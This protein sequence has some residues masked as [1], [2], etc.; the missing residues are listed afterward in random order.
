M[1]CCVGP[2]R[3]TCGHVGRRPPGNAGRGKVTDDTA[4]HVENDPAGKQPASGRFAAHCRDA[5]VTS[6]RATREAWPGRTAHE[7]FE[8]VAALVVTGLVSVLIA[9]A[10]VHLTWE[11][12]VLV[13]MGLADPAGK[14][15]FQ[16][17][18]G[19]IMTVL[20]ALEFNHSIRGVSERRHGII[21]VRTV[22][23][24]ALLARVR[25]FVTI[26]ATHVAPVRAD[27]LLR[28]G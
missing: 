6:L 20:M 19:M 21:Q 10:P 11:V 23:L 24:I 26:D 8:Q 12:L 13:L 16:A 5:A 7:R 22:V 9:A 28:R 15:L 17:I 18:F 25:K 1:D 3:T 27:G 14:R 2:E 4:R